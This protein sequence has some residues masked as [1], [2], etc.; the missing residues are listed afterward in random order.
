MMASE[1]K[2]PPSLVKAAN[3]LY[4]NQGVGGFY[5]GMQAN[6]MRA[7]V[8]NG[9]KMA[10]YDQIKGMIKKSQIVPDGLATQFVAAF[11]A[12]FFM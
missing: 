9:T 3:E 4:K 7:C 10:C 11:G 6:V 12:G 8:L 5:R 2:E 1:G